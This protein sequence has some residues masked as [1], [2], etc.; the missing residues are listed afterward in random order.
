LAVI[1]L[2]ADLP[3][4]PATAWRFLTDPEHTARWWGG[5]V[6]LDARIG[7]A[8]VERWR[9][10]D[11]EVVTSGEVLRCEP[12]HRLELSWADDDWNATTHVTF[13]LDTAHDGS[14][15]TLVH[16]G[17]EC[18]PADDHLT[19]LDAHEAG[20]RHHLES[21]TCYAAA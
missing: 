5:Y 7:G 12:P 11:R 17:W 18:L 9:D 21:L 19:L 1:R 16:D 6:T 3:V 13:T 14:R 8:F 20:W 4:P 2:A 10:G 15:L